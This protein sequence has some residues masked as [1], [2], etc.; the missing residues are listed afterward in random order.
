MRLHRNI[1][2]AVVEGLEE[3]FGNE[4]MAERVVKNQIRKD[5]RWG[6]RDRRFIAES[7]YDLVRW[8]R[9]YL[10]IGEVLEQDE[11]R[12]SKVMAVYLRDKN[13]DLPEWFSPAIPSFE[14]IQKNK[15]KYE[16]N[17]SIRASIPEWLD[18]L[19]KKEL[20]SVWEKE[21]NALNQTTAVVLRVNT[22]KIKKE[23]LILLLKK[24]GVEVEAVT[25]L[26]D[27]LVL[28]KRRDLSQLKTFRNGFFEVQDASSQMVAPFAQVEAGMTVIDSCAGA[29]GKTLH[30]AAQME[31]KG[32]LYSMDVE[33]GKLTELDKR[34]KRAGCRIVTPLLIQEQEMSELKHRAD[35]LLIDA[36]CSG[37]GVL[38]RKPDSKWKLSEAKVEEYKKMQKQILQDYESMLKPGGTLVYVTCSILPSENEKQIEEFLSKNQANYKLEAEQKILASQGFDGF[39][40]ARLRKLK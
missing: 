7:L 29:G 34:I 22:L 10:A 20:G 33:A 38:R 6:S 19:G 30:I 40:M 13:I 2:G 23:K 12:Y 5:R 25:D 8:W 4:A 16:D 18:E 1:V 27:A 24:E 9:W 15:E 32:R 14:Q 37:L 31:N 35:V 28:Q 21:I 26:P 3:I 39:Y 11:E 17:L 36:P